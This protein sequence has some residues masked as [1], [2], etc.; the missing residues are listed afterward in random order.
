M[1]TATVKETRSQL[2]LP[3]FLL[4]CGILSTI[5]WISTDI[6]AAIHYA[7][8]SYK[9]QV[10]SELSAIG[11]PTQI[12]WI[13][14]LFVYNPLLVAFGIGVWK[15]A[16]IKSS[17]RITGLFLSFWGMLGFVW[18]F[19][20]MHMRGAGTSATDTGHLVMSALTVLTITLFI[21]FASGI[22][23]KAFRLYSWMTIITMLILGGYV[24]QQTPRVAENLPTPWLGIIE[25]VMVYAPMVW[26]AVLAI[27]LLRKEKSPNGSAD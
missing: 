7:G 19:F 14:M 26:V 2:S 3:Q 17:L 20:P 5:I 21:G 11:A 12:L 1:K 27:I 4:I 24:G 8:Y 22:K 13:V 25:R 6:F 16:W 10:P 15:S 18:M 23:G 9:D